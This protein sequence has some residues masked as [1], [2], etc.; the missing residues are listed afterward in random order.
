MTS[1]MLV[2]CN[3]QGQC[4]R[5]MFSK[6]CLVLNF[7]LLSQSFM[8][9]FTEECRWSTTKTVVFIT[10][11]TG[12]SNLYQPCSLVDANLFILSQDESQSQLRGHLCLQRSQIR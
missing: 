6:C 4:N 7:S 3:Q 9:A 8:L 1:F 12:S 5:T 2:V 10:N 11:E